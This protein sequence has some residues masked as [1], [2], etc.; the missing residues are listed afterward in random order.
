MHNGTTK[1]LSGLIASEIIFSFAKAYCNRNYLMINPNKTYP[2]LVDIR[3]FILR[4]PADTTINVDNALITPSK[5]IRN[6]GNYTDCHITFNVHIQEMHKKVMR[7]SPFFNRLKDKFE[8]NT[9]KFVIQSLALS[10]INYCLPL[11][12]TA[13]RTLVRMQKLNNFPAKESVGGAKRTDRVTPFI[14]R[15]EW[16]KA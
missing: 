4:I 5:H 7:I 12:D 9:G 16:L 10:I 14:T 15:L 3:L 2:L 8:I 1:E 6:R 11:Y 13:N